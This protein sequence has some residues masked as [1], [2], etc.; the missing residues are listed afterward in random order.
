[1]YVGVV[2]HFILAQFVFAYFKFLRYEGTG[3]S[4]SLKLIQQ[5]RQQSAESQQNKTAENRTTNTAKLA[6]GISSLMCFQCEYS[7]H[8]SD[9]FASGSSHSPR[10]L[11]SRVH[12]LRPSGP[13]RK[14]AERSSLSGLSQHTPACFWL[15]SSAEL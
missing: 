7:C 14:M 10:S 2:L 5:L 11:P 9:S 3:R 6:A 13:G 15:P 8:H 1:M 12:P 4:L